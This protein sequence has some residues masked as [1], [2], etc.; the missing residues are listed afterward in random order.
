MLAGQLDGRTLVIAPPS[1]LNPSNPG[2]W[3]NV[4]SDFRIP[5]DFVST[6]K[7]D[8]AKKMTEYREY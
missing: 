4:F 5:A 7:L 8:E 6:G 3:R 2:S 1:L